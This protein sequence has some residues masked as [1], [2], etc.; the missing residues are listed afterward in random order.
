M[1][2]V[3]QLAFDFSLSKT[4]RRCKQIKP[5]DAFTKCCRNDGYYNECKECRFNHQSKGE[6]FETFQLRLAGQKRCKKCGEIKTFS[7][8]PPHVNSID[9]RD[10]Q[11]CLC[12]NEWHRAYRE[13]NRE[14]C[15]VLRRADRQRNLESYR[16]SARE[17]ARNNKEK[18]WEV[19]YK[20]RR[21]NPER[22]AAID[23]RARLS[24][25]HAVRQ[26]KALRRLREKNA[27]AFPIP[28]A[29]VQAK[30]HFWGNRCWICQGAFESIDHVKPIS[31]GGLHILA[32]LRPTCG[33][34]NSSKGAKWPYPIKCIF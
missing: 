5:F 26:R 11:C 27:T 33:R 24:N 10:V 30:M 18:V 2:I 13:E 17:Y 14:H 4:C 16:R 25:P 15:L 23:R 9:G 12:K 6:T 1:A 20:W 3:P 28:D 22:S 34:C 19:S 8:F 31:K 21:E 29:L 32:N 7:D